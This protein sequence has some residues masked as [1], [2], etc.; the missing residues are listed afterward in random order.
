MIFTFCLL[1]EAV[2]LLQQSFSFFFGTSDMGM[3]CQIDVAFFFDPSQRLSGR[4]LK[5]TELLSLIQS[6]LFCRPV[7]QDAVLLRQKLF[8][9]SWKNDE[10]ENAS[11]FLK[12]RRHMFSHAQKKYAYFISFSQTTDRCRF[13]S[14]GLV[15]RTA[16]YV[17][18]WRALF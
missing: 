14:P 18:F 3:S 11:F 9:N 17:N 4:T 2:V 7:L 16:A 10:K 5:Q 1:F 6:L 13:S 8:E 12:K 15:A